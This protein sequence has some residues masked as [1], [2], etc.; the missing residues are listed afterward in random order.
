MVVSRYSFQIYFLFYEELEKFGYFLLWNF[1]WLASIFFLFFPLWIIYLSFCKNSF[2]VDKI[3][4]RDFLLYIVQLK[5]IYIISTSK[6]LYFST[7]YQ[8]FGHFVNWPR[9]YWSLCKM[10]EILII[11]QNVQ[12]FRSFCKMTM[13]LAFLHNDWLFCKMAN[14]PKWP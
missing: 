5:H 11:M 6:Q 14:F 12:K 2:H 9:G 3:N 1:Y 10:S 4:I 7:G 8:L 13:N